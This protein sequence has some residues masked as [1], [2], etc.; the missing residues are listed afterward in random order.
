MNLDTIIGALNQF[1]ILSAGV[2]F[3]GGVMA[4]LSPCTLPSVFFVVGYAGGYSGNSRLK[5]AGFSLAFV[6]G[7]SLT[8]A[9]LGAMAGLVGGIFQNNSL[10]MLLTGILLVVMG[11]HLAGVLPL[12]E[13][14]AVSPKRGKRGI[15]GA[16]LMGVPFAFIASPCTAPVTASVLAWVAATGSAALGML[17]LFCY[18]MGRSVPLFLAGTFTGLLKNLDW[19]QRYSDGFQR[20]AGVLLAGLGLWLLWSQLVD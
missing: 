1:S 8:L 9:L 3:A 6:L 4:G 17:L 5:A 20:I 10:I 14:P 7:L 18:A 13:L 16:F 12:P 2:F 11:A 15:W 19:F